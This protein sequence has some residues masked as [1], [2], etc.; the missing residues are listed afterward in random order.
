M[1]WEVGG[2]REVQEGGSICTPMLIHV[3][4]WQKQTQ[5]C[6]KVILQQKI[7]KFSLKKS[8]TGAEYN[9]LNSL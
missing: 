2:G 4:V 1:G 8:I 5:H 9:N 7:N 6:I 3:D